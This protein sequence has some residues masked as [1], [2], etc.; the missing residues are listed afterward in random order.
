MKNILL[1]LL[2]M[3]IIQQSAS[4]C[5]LI[6]LTI[7]G[8][9]AHLDDQLIDLGEPDDMNTPQDW[10]GPVMFKMDTNKQCSIDMDIIEEP[11]LSDRKKLFIPTYS[12]SE[13]TLYAIDM[14]S[15][16][17]LWE[18]KIFYG[19]TTYQNGI[20]KAGGERIYL[21]EQCNV[22]TEHDDNIDRHNG[23]INKDE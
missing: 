22:V 13:R 7:S 1:V 11:I 10:H 16:T 21:D 5:E 19:Q 9:Y 20:L 2:M 23:S 6:R 8:R 18:S 17:V 14:M 12:G 4:G 15:C 3:L